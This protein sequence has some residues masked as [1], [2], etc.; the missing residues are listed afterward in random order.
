MTASK[1]E[2]GPDPLTIEDILDVAQ[3]RASVSLSHDDAFVSEIRKGRDAL[4]RLWQSSATVYGVTTGVGDSCEKRIPTEMVERFPLLLSRFHGCGMGDLLSV[5]TCRAVLMVR[6]ASLRS[7]WSAVRFELIERLTLLLEKDIIP[8]IPSE[9]SVGA[10]GDLTPLSYVAAVVMGERDVYYGG[11]IVPV[12]DVYKSLGIEPLILK[13]KEG[14]AIMNGTSVMTAIACEAVRRAEQIVS[15]GAQLTALIVEALILNKGHFD[16]RIFDRKPY[17][18]QRR[19]AALISDAIGHDTDYRFDDRMRVQATYAVRCAPHIL[20]VL[21]DSLEWIRRHVE[22]EINSVNDNPLIDP[23]IG[24]V[25]HGG[26]FY[27]GHIAFAMDS[28]KNAVANCAD[29]IDR[30]MALLVNER[31]N[32]GLPANLTGTTGDLAHINHGFKAVHI[33]TSAFAAEAL[34]NSISASIFSRSTES[35]NQDK[36]S[37]G[38]IAARDAI[39]VLELTEQV[40]AA[41]LLGATQALELRLREGGVQLETLTPEIQLLFKSIRAVSAFVEE[42]RPLEKDLRTLTGLIRDGFKGGAP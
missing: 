27:G 37:M 38:T 35:H 28:L 12:A 23:E 7:G 21:A 29:L 2:I 9:G 14:I 41:T 30:Q 13:A 8:C 11:Q 6:L 5:E 19:V 10:S 18:G 39:R 1:I 4:D 15:L 24:D 31:R 17:P 36:V 20:G 22:I 25:L 42:D 33:A 16:L 26:N 3:G 32:N 34:K 40:L